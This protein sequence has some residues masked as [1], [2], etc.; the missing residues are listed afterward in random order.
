MKQSLISS[1]C[2]EVLTWFQPPK[3][4]APPSEPSTA[5]Q[6]RRQTR[7]RRSTAD[8]SPKSP[9]PEQLNSE[10]LA[11]ENGITSDQEREVR[12]AFGLFAVKHLAFKENV[13]GVIKVD[14]VRRC[15]MYV[16]PLSWLDECSS[17]QCSQRTQP[18]S[19]SSRPP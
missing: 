8:Q 11:R 3:R 4:R 10:E 7:N 9:E 19:F 6:S 1:S 13:E 14:D 2:N 17:H 5:K 12:D 15:L 16:L 18:P